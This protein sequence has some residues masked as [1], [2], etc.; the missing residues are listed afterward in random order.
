MRPRPLHPNRKREEQE[1]DIRRRRES[2][3]FA[4]GFEAGFSFRQYADDLDSLEE[5]HS[6]DEIADFELARDTYKRALRVVGRQSHLRL[7]YP[8]T[9][10]GL[11]LDPL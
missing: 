11:G 2:E 9:L 1:L 3:I 8:F 10:T 7:G 5:F 4:N 6:A